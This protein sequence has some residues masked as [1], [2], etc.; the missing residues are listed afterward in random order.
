MCDVHQVGS[1]T[2]DQFVLAM[3]L[4]SQ[5]VKGVDLP[6]SI[7]PEML[8]ASSHD[9]GFGVSDSLVSLSIA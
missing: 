7:T 6:P 9:S 4:I 5:K 8:S 1:L 2:R 3:H